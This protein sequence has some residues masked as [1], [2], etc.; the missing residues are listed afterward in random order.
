MALVVQNA[1]GTQAGADAY[2]TVAQFK[3]YHT[4]RGRDYSAY[5]DTAIE[6][7]IV[8]ATDYLDDRFS[9]IGEPASTDRSTEWPRHYAYD[10]YDDYVE[11][12]P[13]EV[14]EATHEYAFIAL[15]ADLIPTPDRDGSGQTV[16]SKSET[17]GPITE[18]VEYVSGGAFQLPKYPS[19]DRKIIKRGLVE[20]GGRLIR[21]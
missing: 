11:G 16:Q 14:I 13:V 3:T 21:G 10:R 1:S 12:V 18:S 2:V 19:A 8:R 9:F 5:D 15:S 20:R 4:A 7:A 6:Q 17:V